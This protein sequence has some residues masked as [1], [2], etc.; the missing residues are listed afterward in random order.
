MIE[1][2]S[3]VLRELKSEWERDAARKI[4]TRI[5]RR[6]F[7]ADAEPI[8]GKLDVIED[9]QRLEELAD[10]ARACPDL[11]AFQAQLPP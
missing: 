6:R 5:L 2:K 3:P 7:G 1:P 8:L 9:D 4:I 10:L 11:G